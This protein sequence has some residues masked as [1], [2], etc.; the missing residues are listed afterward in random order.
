MDT[1]S[2]TGLYKYIYMYVYMY[3]TYIVIEN[4]KTLLSYHLLKVADIPE[5]LSILGTTEQ[6]GGGE[7]DASD[8]DNE[9]EGY[10]DPQPNVHTKETGGKK[11][12]QPCPLDRGGKRRREEGRRRRGEEGRRGGGEK[13]RRG[14]GEEREGEDE[15]RRGR[16]EGGKEEGRKR[17]R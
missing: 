3:V 6:R 12:H 5:Y 17:K 4:R 8:D 2:H 14:G 10:P 15:G 7:D 11:H 9:R 16:G 13:G 1:P